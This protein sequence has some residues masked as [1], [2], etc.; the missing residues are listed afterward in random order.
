MENVK[1]VAKVPVRIDFAGGWTDIRPYTLKKQGWVLNA[2]I[3]RFIV[4]T[5]TRKSTPPY[6]S[7]AYS[8]PVPTGSGLGTS[9]AMNVLYLGLLNPDKAHNR[10]NLAETAYQ[11]ETLLGIK[12]GKQDQY[13]AAFGGFNLMRFYRGTVEV[14]RITPPAAFVRELESKITLCYTG[15]SR[16]SSEV[17]SR[18]W[19]GITSG[20]VGLTQCFDEMA[21]IARRMAFLFKHGDMDGIVELLIA[22][23]FSQNEVS[24]FGED[25]GIQKAGR[26]ADLV[27]GTLCG[28]VCGAGGGGC[29]F[30]ISKT[31]RDRNALRDGLLKSNNGFQIIPFHF[32]EKGFH[33]VD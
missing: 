12:G 19:D 24:P 30:F 1:V 17:H 21:R 8:S 27:H 22:H 33:I 11:F 9:S 29:V 31:V 26:I 14:E 4:G 5:L 18:V 20:H 16:L 23:N 28:K 6:I 13:A 3:D 15:E 32:T 7:V 2:T 10:A 25:S